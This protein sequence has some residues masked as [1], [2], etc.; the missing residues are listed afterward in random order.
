MSASIAMDAQE[1]VGE[2]PASQVMPKLSFD[3]PRNRPAP[4]AGPG[5]ERLE[6]IRND[7]VEDCLV[8]RT[9]EE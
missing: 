6:V 7:A 4:I 9:E 8:R 2:D 5:Q 1:P 3:E